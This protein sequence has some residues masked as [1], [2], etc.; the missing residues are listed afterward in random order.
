[1]GKNKIIYAI[2]ALVIMASCESYD[3][4]DT[5]RP[6]VIG[7]SSDATNI[8]VPNG[9]TRDRDVDIFISEAANVDRTFAVSIVEDLTEVAPE[10]YSFD[11]TVV[12]LANERVATFT[13]TG[14]DVSLTE[15][16]LPLTLKVEPVNGILSGS[17][18]TALIFK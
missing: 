8:K 4:Y 14:I 5:S 3:D 17:T 10:N 1:M 12:I 7:F 18:V 16:K 11:P 9:G 15:E 6:I 2:I 13:I